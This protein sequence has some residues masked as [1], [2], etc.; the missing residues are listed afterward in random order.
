MRAEWWRAQAARPQRYTLLALFAA[1]ILT[2]CSDSEVPVYTTQFAAFDTAVDLSIVGIQ[3]ERAAAAANEIE[4]DFHFF[5]QALYD[6][7]SA[8]MLRLNQRLA[9]GET[10]AAPPSLIPLIARAQTLSDESNGLFNPALGRLT[11]LWGLDVAVPPSHAPPSAA[12]IAAVLAVQP[13]LSD[14]RLDGLELQS[15]NPAVQL[16]FDP[17]AVAFATDRA[18]DALRAQGVRSAMINAGGDVR[19][20]GSRSGRPWRVA[21][22]RASGSGVIGIID[23]SGDASLF[24]ASSQRRN[25]IHDGA[26]YHSV[27]D[28]RTGR[29]ADGALSASVLHEGEA[30]AAAAAAQA[31]MIAGAREWPAIA[32]RMG[33]QYA[34][35]IDAENRL[36]MTPAM[37]QILDLLDTNAERIITDPLEVEPPST[38]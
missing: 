7:G 8:R 10:F 13:R 9:S 18:V 31:L 17:V 27:L 30:L 24:T 1:A 36:H 23:I 6:E 2:A 16:D 33:I 28:P 21:V 32:A 37:A 11:R 3:R 25:F 26:V 4:R 12:A 35:V 38:P 29:P 34:L 20:I 19:A 14:L 22:P 5:E 15:T